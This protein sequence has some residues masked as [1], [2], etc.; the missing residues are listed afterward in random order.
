MIKGDLQNTEPRKIQYQRTD[1]QLRPET[2][3]LPPKN[4]I[5]PIQDNLPGAHIKTYCCSHVLFAPK[6]EKTNLQST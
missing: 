4:R 3:F 6:S 2:V 1:G 5:S